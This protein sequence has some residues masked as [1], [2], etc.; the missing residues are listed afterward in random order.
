MAQT[1]WLADSST[2][3]RKRLLVEALSS[4]SAALVA[5]AR[6]PRLFMWRNFLLHSFACVSF[7]PAVF[8]A[9]IPSRR[10]TGY[11]TTQTER[12]RPGQAKPR[13][14]Q[15]APEQRTLDKPNQSHAP[16]PNAFMC[17]LF[18]LY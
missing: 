5:L 2:A 18:A 16:S 4:S 8:F 1:K 6:R 13:Q 14:A 10:Y 12:K 17:V 9:T 7:L 15:A 11:N 3:A